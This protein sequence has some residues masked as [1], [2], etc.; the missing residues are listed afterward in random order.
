MAL[1]MDEQ[2]ILAE[3]ERRLASADPGLA[4]RLSSFGSGEARRRPP[5]SHARLATS[6]VTL[7]MVAFVAL[8]VYALIPLRSVPGKVAQNRASSAPKHTAMTAG[9]PSTG[10]SPAPLGPA[11][12]IGLLPTPGQAAVGEP[13]PA[14]GSGQPAG[15]P[16]PT[17]TA[18]ANGAP[19]LAPAS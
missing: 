12:E 9:S 13:T 4:A 5:W 11:P 6:F 14:P 10:R 19:A 1:S 3:I 16:A 17:R 8:A 2:R 15:R 7:T 18:P